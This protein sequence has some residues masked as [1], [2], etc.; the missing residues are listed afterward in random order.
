MGRR[1]TATEAPYEAESPEDSHR[2]G[3]LLL[4]GF[5]ERLTPAEAEAFN[6]LRD[7]LKDKGGDLRSGKTI[8]EIARQDPRIRDFDSAMSK[9]SLPRATVVYRAVDPEFLAPPGFVKPGTPGSKATKFYSDIVR[10]NPQAIVGNRFLDRSFTSTSLSP[11]IGATSRWGGNEMVTFRIVL[12]KGAHAQY[13]ENVI[14]RSKDLQEVLLHRGHEF[15]ITKYR[16]TQSVTA[17]GKTREI[18]MYDV[19]I[20]GRTA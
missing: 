18:R 6:A 20:T 14:K 16:G 11:S 19:E 7:V 8:D 1:N 3:A 10:E 15:T 5:A 2:I 13:V 12:P 9:A 4:D 17:N